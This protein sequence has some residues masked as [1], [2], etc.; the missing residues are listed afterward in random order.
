M[1]RLKYYGMI[2]GNQI[3][4]VLMSLKCCFM[5]VTLVV[6]A[7]FSCAD[8]ITESRDAGNGSGQSGK[9]VPASV[10]VIFDQSCALSGCHRDFQRPFLTA[11]VAYD[12]IV[13]APSTQSPGL[14]FIE[15]GDPSRSY[16]YLKITGAS[17][18][19]GTRMPQA[20]PPLSAAQ[21]DTI[22]VWIENGAP[23]E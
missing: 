13:R 2:T 6:F 9:K 14:N 1:R 22:R 23:S 8:H 17:G 15:P 20:S 11:E 7:L 19:I 3:N 16:L 10:Q 18:I 4:G 5:A 21:I 12:N